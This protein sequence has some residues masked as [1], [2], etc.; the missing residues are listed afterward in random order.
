MVKQHNMTL[1][2]RSVS[3][4]IIWLNCDYITSHCLA[5]FSGNWF[6]VIDIIE[7]GGMVSEC[8]L[9]IN[10]TIQSSVSIVSAT[11]YSI[12]LVKF[13]I[14]WFKKRS[15]LMST[16][17]ILLVI[18]DFRWKYWWAKQAK[19]ICGV[20]KKKKFLKIP[21]LFPFCLLVLFHPVP[22]FSLRPWNTLLT[23][24]LIF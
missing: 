9:V 7:V 17:L 24:K 15:L 6:V 18:T 10:V 8:K 21:W 22:P 14:S 12:K 3:V 23:S 20:S 19:E 1:R 5:N 13:R 2:R 16:P 11:W 4:V